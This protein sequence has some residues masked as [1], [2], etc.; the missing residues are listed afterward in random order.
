LD[1]AATMLHETQTACLPEI[2]RLFNEFN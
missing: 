1:E 2:K